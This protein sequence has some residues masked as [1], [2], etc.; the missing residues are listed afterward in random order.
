M[1]KGREVSLVDK[2]HMVCKEGRMLISKSLQRHAVLWYHHYLQYSGH[3]CLEETMSATMYWK[4]ICTTI[5]SIMKSCKSCQVNKKWKLKYGHLLSKPVIMIPWRALCVYTLKSLTAIGPYLAHR[6]FG[7]CSRLTTF[8]IFV[9]WL[10]LIIQN[11]AEL[12]SSNSSV[13][14]LYSACSINDVSRESI[15]G[16]KLFSFFALVCYKKPR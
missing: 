12:S 15:L 10:R 4:G 11:V 2:T 13:S 3:T 7:L 14:H 9:R 5:W 6:V 16:P 8:R 1:D